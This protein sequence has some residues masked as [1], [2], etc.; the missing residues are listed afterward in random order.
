[1]FDESEKARSE[2]KTE[3]SDAMS[4]HHAEPKTFEDK[5]MA[6]LQEAKSQ[7]KAI[8]A[9]AKGTLAQAEVDAV[10]RLKATRREIDKKSQE[11]RTAGETKLRQT[12]PNR[13]LWLV[14]SAGC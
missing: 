9:G 10:N 8:E 6:H 12:S 14:N 11:L 1:M 5:V 4:R 13:M 3:R 2:N 7:I